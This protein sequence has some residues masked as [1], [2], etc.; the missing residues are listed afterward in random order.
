[1]PLTFCVLC[2]SQ[3]LRVGSRI[4]GSVFSVQL[5]VPASHPQIVVHTGWLSSIVSTG[6]CA[7]S[8]LLCSPVLVNAGCSYS[9]TTA[10]AAHLVLLANENG[11]GF[12]VQPGQQQAGGT[13]TAWMSGRNVLQDFRKLTNR[14]LC[15]PSLAGPSSG[16]PVR[17]GGGC[18]PRALLW[19]PPGC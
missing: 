5:W 9:M 11:G 16:H 12:N 13:L 19:G 8:L 4:L 14:N 6:F 2:C 10:V 15:R 17:P 7:P 18:M 1:M 3:A